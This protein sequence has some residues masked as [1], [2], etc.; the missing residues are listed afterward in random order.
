MHAGQIVA[1]RGLQ[2]QSPE[3]AADAVAGSGKTD[4][5]KIWIARWRLPEDMECAWFAPQHST[6]SEVYS[7][8]VDTFR[9]VDLLEWPSGKSEGVIRLKNG[10]RLRFWTLGNSIAGRGH[11]YHRI[12]IDEAAFTKDGDNT[13]DDS[14]MGLWE[15]A[16]KPTLL[17]FGGSALVCSNTNGKD[18]DNFFYNICTD[19]K[20]GFKEYHATTLD[21]PLLPKRLPRRNVGRRQCGLRAAR[22]GAWTAT[23]KAGQRSAGLRAGISC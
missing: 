13:L 18:P 15:K 10:G 3:G 5:A 4:F 6:W 22:P 7:A 9:R 19:Q 14:M 23:L 1:Y 12:V 21:N 8:M 2:G 11:R 20:Y 17:D 16:I